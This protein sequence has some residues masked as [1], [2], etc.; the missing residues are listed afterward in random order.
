MNS[1]IN[2]KANEI[3]SRVSKTL[4]NNN[5]IKDSSFTNNTKFWNF[6]DSRYSFDKQT[7]Q[8]YNWL[9][10]IPNE[11]GTHNAEPFILQ[12]SLDYILTS[13]KCIFSFYYKTNIKTYFVV[14]L[15]YYKNEEFI[16]S[17]T[18]T[19]TLENT[20]SK[21]KRASILL[22]F[23]DYG[24][25]FEELVSAS[26]LMK[27]EI[28]LGW[29]GNTNYSTSISKLQLQTGS[30]ATDYNIAPQETFSLINQQAD[31][32]TSTVSNT[33]ASKTEVKQ[34]TDKITTEVSKK[35]GNDEL[36][37]KIQQDPE[38]VQIAWNNIGDFIKYVN[39]EMQ[40]LNNN[41]QL[42]LV[43]NKTGMKIYEDGTNIGSIGSNRLHDNASYK[44]LSFDLTENGK[45]MAWAAM[46]NANDETYTIKLGYYK[47]GARKG[48]EEQ[49]YLGVP[50][51]LARTYI[52]SKRKH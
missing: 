39:A 10:I 33:Y 6:S 12:E 45:Y 1:A 23:S 26:T 7:G 50:L 4:Q 9:L 28:V 47:E 34:T 31:S 20:N 25:E 18:G 15:N 27:I 32:I 42:L 24:D 16:S 40:I 41:K 3:N 48:E 8:A 35:V 38:S 19:A 49:I 43:L 36:S 14:N 13:G 29:G 44:G 30:V 5:M 11:G 52:A 46:T 2:L 37:T 22:N 51:H 17:V 21:E